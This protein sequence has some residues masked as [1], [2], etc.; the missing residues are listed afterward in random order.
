M[1]GFIHAVTGLEVV[2]GLVSL[3]DEDC[4]RRTWIERGIRLDGEKD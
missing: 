2:A 3:S 4:G 1:K